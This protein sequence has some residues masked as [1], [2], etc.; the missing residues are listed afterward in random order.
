MSKWTER[1]TDIL[2]VVT[3]TLVNGVVRA[4]IGNAATNAG[5]ASN[6]P[7]YGIDGFVSRPADADEDGAARVLYIND[8][9]QKIGIAS[10]DRR[11]ATKVGDLQPG[12]KA[13]VSPGEARM[14]LKDADDLIVLYS[15]RQEDGTSMMIAVNGKTGKI[16]A[17]VG[18][19]KLEISMDEIT[20]AINGGPSL[21]LSKLLNNIALMAGALNLDGGDVTVGLM[22]GGIRPS[23]TPAQSALYGPQGQVGVASLTVKIAP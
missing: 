1:L 20:L 15:A 12:D 23:V 21:K 8:G 22:P 5:V 19:T 17:S 10:A 18:L 7:L 9:N 13:I 2:D 3:T 14:L 4:N 16:T 6:V 11:Y